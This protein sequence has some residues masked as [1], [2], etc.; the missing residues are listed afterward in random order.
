[1]DVVR[2]LLGMAISQPREAPHML[3]HGLIVLLDVAG[4]NKRLD[5]LT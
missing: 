3:A 1:V 4:R 2:D 5:G